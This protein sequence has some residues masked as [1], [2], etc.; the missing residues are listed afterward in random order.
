[1]KNYE[2][3]KEIDDYYHRFRQDIIVDTYKEYFITK[4]KGY[5][6]YDYELWK[7]DDYNCKMEKIDLGN[8]CYLEF[9]NNFLIVHR[10]IKHDL[11]VYY[12]DEI[13]ELPNFTPIMRSNALGININETSDYYIVNELG[14]DNNGDLHTDRSRL[15]DKKKKEEV[16]IPYNIRTNHIIRNACKSSKG[17]IQ[18]ALYDYDNKTG[19]LLS[20]GIK[21]GFKNFC[22]YAYDKFLIYDDL[23]NAMIVDYS[24]NIINKLKIDIKLDDSEK[25]FIDNFKNGVAKFRIINYSPDGGYSKCGMID[26]NGKIII[27]N[28]EFLYTFDNDKF[29]FRKKFNYLITDIN[30]YSNNNNNNMFIGKSISSFK[31][32]YI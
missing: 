5:K 8:T 13:Y 10:I 19:A 31:N 28:C 18:I 22:E 30:K 25:L 29:I 27:S 14:E 16:N 1:M 11:K 12:I 15:I 23:N 20:N 9:K 32:K 26:S 7:Y 24:G 4:R 2:I 17:D 6:N 21:K 3:Y